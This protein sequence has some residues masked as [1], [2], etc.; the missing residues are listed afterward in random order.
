MKRTSSILGSVFAAGYLLMSVADVRAEEDEVPQTAQQTEGEAASGRETEAPAPQSTPAVQL[1]FDEYLTADHEHR[2]KLQREKW[3]SHPNARE[4]N[5]ITYLEF[6]GKHKKTKGHLFMFPQ[7]GSVASVLDLAK[8]A[9]DS[10]FD[11]FIFLPGPELEDRIPYD[12]EDQTNAQIAASYLQYVSATLETIGAHD[13]SNLILL[14]GN[15]AGW[16]IQ[17]LTDGELLKPDAVILMNAFYRDRDANSMLA[18]YFSTF[19]GYTLDLVTTDS[20]NWLNEAFSRRKFVCEK[21]EKPKGAT[22]FFKSEDPEET[23][24]MFGRYLRKTDF[25]AYRNRVRRNAGQNR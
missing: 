6:E 14:E 10:N 5:G 4:V 18:E 7:W 15:T 13:Q 3:S 22:R 9:A 2:K 17:Q 1:S 8:I 21:Q 24:R 23:G 16:L 12:D 11:T 20:N 25:S 19:K